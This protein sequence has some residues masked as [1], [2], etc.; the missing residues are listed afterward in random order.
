MTQV[1]VAALVDTQVAWDRRSDMRNR[2]EKLGHSAVEPE[3]PYWSGAGVTFED[4]DGW[5][6]VLCNA[7]GIYFRSVTGAALVT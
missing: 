3:N 5:R 4:P 7:S 6:L 1:T 2:F